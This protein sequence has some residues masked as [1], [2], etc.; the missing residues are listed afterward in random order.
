MTSPHD[1]FER[2]FD[3]EGSESGLSQPIPSELAGL[4]RLLDARGRAER[5]GLSAEALERISA[6][7]DL[8]LPVEGGS[9]VVIARIDGGGAPRIGRFWRTAAL[10]AAII[11]AIGGGL[12]FLRG[13][14][15]SDK[16]ANDAVLADGSGSDGVAPIAPRVTVPSLD[17]L[18]A[19]VAPEHVERA[20]ASATVSASPMVVALAGRGAS[21][22]F[23]FDASFEVSFE[24]VRSHGLDDGLAADLSA[25]WEPLLG[26]ASFLDGGA[27]TYED[28]SAE[29]A[30][31]AAPAS[32]R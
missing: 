27:V 18:A 31:L 6:L 16:S 32:F 2:E 10:A 7:S 3:A 30:A 19:K 29:F 9:P 11:A 22:D 17:A 28:L 23:A 5:S 15:A 20:L 12:L 25:D 8:Q 1:N 13:G 26:N 21:G 14:D 4:G 24:G